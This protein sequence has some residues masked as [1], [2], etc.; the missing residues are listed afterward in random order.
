MAQVESAFS[1]QQVP[2]GCRTDPPL[3]PGRA[4]VGRSGLSRMVTRLPWLLQPFLGDG[5]AVGPGMIAFPLPL[6]ASL[7]L[8]RS[9][10]LHESLPLS[11]TWEVPLT[12]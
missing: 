2:H 4:V 12:P 11:L 8:L 1:S 6:P 3:V 10:I 9:L 5:P 7:C